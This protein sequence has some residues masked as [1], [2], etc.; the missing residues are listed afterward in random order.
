MKSPKARLNDFWRNALRHG[1]ILRDPFASEAGIRLIATTTA[2]PASPKEIYDNERIVG[3]E[4]V[5]RPPDNDHTRKAFRVPMTALFSSFRR[6]DGKCVAHSL[7][8]DIVAVGEDEERALRKLSLA[9]KTYVEYGV[10]NNWVEDVL[11][12]APPE[13]W[14]RFMAAS[15]LRTTDPICID[16]DRN[17][18]RCETY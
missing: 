6:P 1:L 7:D 3:P 15:S 5:D 2:T 4:I 18:I 17:G 9:V 11:F 13:Y 12:P 14:E 10:S 8:F 16:D